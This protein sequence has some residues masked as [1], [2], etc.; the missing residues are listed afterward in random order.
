MRWGQG[1]KAIPVHAQH[2]NTA[3][4]VLPPAGR[5]SPAEFIADYPGELETI[6]SRF[7]HQE[8]PDPVDLFYGKDAAAVANR[9]GSSMSAHGGDRG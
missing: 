9:S 2:G 1:D 5:T 4:H 7:G 8:L 3:G 6:A